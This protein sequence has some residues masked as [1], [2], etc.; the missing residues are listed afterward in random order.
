MSSRSL[1]TVIESKYSNID[2]IILNDPS[3]VHLKD[4]NVEIF[5]N[6][7]T[8]RNDITDTPDRKL[9]E[10]KITD[11]N[12]TGTDINMSNTNNANPPTVS[13]NHNKSKKRKMKQTS[14]FQPRS[15]V[16]QPIRESTKRRVI[17]TTRFDVDTYCDNEEQTQLQ[18]ALKISKLE[19]QRLCFENEIPLGPTY[20]PSEA[21]FE[22]T[23]AYIARY[24]HVH[25]IT[26]CIPIISLYTYTH[27]YIPTY[28]IEEEASKYG[29]CKIVPPKSYKNPCQVSSNSTF[30][31]PTNKQVYS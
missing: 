1:D 10:N 12:H 28:S 29:V 21:E 3:E 18:A 19:T 15:P 22:N 27:I 25:I 2:E 30:I 7:T 20:Y 26:K 13:T 5:N 11:D 16:T 24:V 17:P 4:Q 6:N 23:M 31:F 14:T 8:N 9:T